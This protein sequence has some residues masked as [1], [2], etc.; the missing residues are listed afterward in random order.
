LKIVRLE[1]SD[2][3]KVAGVWASAFLNYPLMIYYW[4]RLVGRR[5]NLVR[6][7]GWAINYGLRHGEVYTTPE[8]AGIAIY[9]RSGGTQFAL[10]RYAA[11]GYLQLPQIMAIPHIFS[12][13]VMNNKVVRS[14][15][16]EIIPGPHWYLW[17]LAVDPDHQ[18]KGIGRS[19]LQPGLEN[20]KKALLPFYLETHVEGNLPFYLKCGFELVHSGQVPGSDLRFWCFLR[21]P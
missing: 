17:G 7:L 19:L 1:P 14:A 5:R 16:K 10:W 21:K 18:G 8:L 20:A 11:A 6:F 15:H 4:P 3:N 2:R 13:L 9:L 12:R